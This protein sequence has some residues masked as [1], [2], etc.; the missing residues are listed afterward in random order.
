MS[1]VVPKF[2]EGSDDDDGGEDLQ[3]GLGA[4]DGSFPA[5]GCGMKPERVPLVGFSQVFRFFF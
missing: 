3:P 5:L 1:L 2:G 4:S